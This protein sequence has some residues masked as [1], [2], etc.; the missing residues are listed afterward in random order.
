MSNQKDCSIC[1]ETYNL[2]TKKEVIC[3]FADC[4]FSN[5]KTCVRTYLLGT[6][7]DPH[8][9]TCKKPWDQKFIIANLNRAFCDKEYKA[10]RKDLLVERE[11]SKLPE[12][13]HLAERQKKI[14]VEQQKTKLLDEKIIKLNK[15][16]NSLKVERTQSHNAV[17]RIKRGTDSVNDEKT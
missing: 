7:A 9:M 6:T 5:C 10:H 14:N 3:P 17:Y 16:L 1:C 13:M 2:S 8:C 12:T 4:N 11:I 15:E